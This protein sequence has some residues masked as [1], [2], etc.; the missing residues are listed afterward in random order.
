[1]NLPTSISAK[2]GNY[3]KVNL[4]WTDALNREGESDEERR[5]FHYPRAIPP[6][7][8]S[9]MHGIEAIS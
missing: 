8:I 6:V 3:G 9:L 7:L 5:V 2:T 4:C 1:M